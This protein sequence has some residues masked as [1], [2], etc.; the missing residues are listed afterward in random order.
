MLSSTALCQ[1]T[2]ASRYLQQ[3]CKHFAHKTDVSF[4]THQGKC[5]FSCGT[6]DLAADDSTLNIS[7]QAADAAGLAETKDVIE[8][9]L[10]RFAFREE[11]P[12]LAWAD[13]IAGAQ[14]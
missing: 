1:T 11:L 13:R 4:D 7:V 6:A 10:L 12:S 3:L 2:N 14:A 9:H 8:R 5:S